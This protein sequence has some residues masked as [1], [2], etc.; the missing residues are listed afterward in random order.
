MTIQEKTEHLMK[1]IAVNMR[2]R[3]ME[4]RITNKKLAEKCGV[5]SNYVSYLL[6]CRRFPSWFIFVKISDVLDCTPESLMSPIKSEDRVT[7]LI[8]KVMK[9]FDSS[10][11]SSLLERLDKKTVKRKEKMKENNPCDFN[12][13][14][15][16][17]PEGYVGD[18]LY[19]RKEKEEN[20]KFVF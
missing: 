3:M 11:E 20:K 18:V 17:L 8:D 6:N 1:T 12:E 10:K 19:E 9:M 15:F 14:D 16:N 2:M 4:K 5:S 7:N 13:E